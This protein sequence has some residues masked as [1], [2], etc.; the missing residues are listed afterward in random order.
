MRI[1]KNVQS[2]SS[3]EKKVFVSALLRIKKEGSVHWHH[4]V[5]VPSVL[6]CEPKDAHRNGA[7]RGH[8]FYLGIVNF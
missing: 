8:R 4:A 3:D 1:R 5:M 2:L 7:H 6:S